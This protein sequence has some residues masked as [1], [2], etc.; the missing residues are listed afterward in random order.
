MCRLTFLS[1]SFSLCLMQR[2]QGNCWH[3]PSGSK[4]ENISS[5]S[6]FASE[7][8]LQSVW[9]IQSRA[10][11]LRPPR[12]KKICRHS[13]H[14]WSTHA[15]NGSMIVEER[16]GQP[17]RRQ[18]DDLKKKSPVRSGMKWKNSKVLELH[19]RGIS[20]E[21][22]LSYFQTEEKCVVCVLVNW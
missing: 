17:L 9:W 14:F 19:G 18:L 10:E 4:L 16:G 1:V 13:A 11:K 21:L 7:L 6:F 15:R 12:G 2:W 20:R 8:N 22:F 3:G 5:Q